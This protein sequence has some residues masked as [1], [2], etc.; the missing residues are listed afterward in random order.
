VRYKPEGHWFDSPWC[1]DD[2]DDDDNDECVY[3]WVL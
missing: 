3:E 1:D 2:D